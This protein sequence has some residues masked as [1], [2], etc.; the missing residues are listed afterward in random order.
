[1]RVCGKLA[2]RQMGLNDKGERVTCPVQR[3]SAKYL[4]FEISLRQNLPLHLLWRK[5]DFRICRTFQ[6]VFVHFV[7][8]RTASCVTT[9]CVNHH[10]AAGVPRDGVEFH[11]PTFQMERSV[12]SMEN[13]TQ[14]EIHLSLS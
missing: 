12:D 3:E 11:R 9:C 4:N 13:I 8:A 10:Q 5:S 1:M 14:G 7:I 6:N 2:T